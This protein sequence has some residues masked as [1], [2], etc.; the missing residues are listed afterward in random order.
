MGKRINNKEKDNGSPVARSG[1]KQKEQIQFYRS[2]FASMEC[3]LFIYDVANNNLLWINDH[4]K[5]V[6]GEKLSLGKIQPETIQR[7]F[8]Q[9]D[10]ELYN[11]VKSYFEKKKRGSYSCFHKIVSSDGESKWIY[12]NLKI[13][14]K[15]PDNKTIELL[16]FAV[17]FS[18][19]LNNNKYTDKVLKEKLKKANIKVIDIISKRELEVIKY[20]A[21]G[22]KTKEIAEELNI[23]FHTVN[24]HRKNILKKLDLR[25]IAAMVNFAVENGLH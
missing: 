5:K 16:G 15:T 12:T 20:F 4:H 8:H 3:V 24:N 14:R 25:N 6:I 13:F 21:N 22:Y 23:S 1:L 17:D 2:V 10:M 7:Y 9:D 19:D 18:N 11:E